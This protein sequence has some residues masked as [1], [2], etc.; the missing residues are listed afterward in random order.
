MLELSWGG[1]KP[2]PISDGSTRTF[3][4]D[5]DKITITGYCEGKDYKIGFGEVTGTVLPAKPY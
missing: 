3:L 5:Y 1:S 2:I 4:L